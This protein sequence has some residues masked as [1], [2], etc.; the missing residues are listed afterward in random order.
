MQ[1]PEGRSARSG[2]SSP[3]VGD[4]VS[5]YGVAGPGVTRQPLAKTALVSAMARAHGRGE[6]ERTRDLRRRRWRRAAARARAGSHAR[7]IVSLWGRKDGAAA[8][9]AVGLG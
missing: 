7:A 9:G 4:G 5:A 1:S 2:A 8:R 3:E 6:G